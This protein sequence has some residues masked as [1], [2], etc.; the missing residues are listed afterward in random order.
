ME[1]EED[2]L[3]ATIRLNFRLA[4]FNFVLIMHLNK[5]T[6]ACTFYHQHMSNDR[7]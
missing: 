5:C 3:R 4:R 2:T 7:N 1:I 6:Y